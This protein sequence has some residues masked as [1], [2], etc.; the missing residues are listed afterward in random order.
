M[1]KQVNGRGERFLRDLICYQKIKPALRRIENNAVSIPASRL[2]QNDSIVH[3]FRIG[4]VSP[5]MAG[6]KYETAIL[7]ILCTNSRPVRARETMTTMPRQ[8]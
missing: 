6:V 5:K 1:T 8:K 3:R 2:Q 7:P 4:F